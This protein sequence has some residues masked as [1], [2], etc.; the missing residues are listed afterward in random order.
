MRKDCIVPKCVA[1]H[2]FGNAKEDCTRMYAMTIAGVTVVPVSASI[3]DAE[4]REAAVPGVP[5][6]CDAEVKSPPE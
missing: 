1:C 4:E 6:D 2:N 5:T 3:I